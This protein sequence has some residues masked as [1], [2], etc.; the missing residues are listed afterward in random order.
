MKYIKVEILSE[1]FWT[2]DSLHELAT[3]IE[4]GDLLDTMDGDSVEVTGGH[5]TAEV[6]IVE[7]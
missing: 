4:C 7:A 3:Q 6:K 2:A 1:E 5:Y